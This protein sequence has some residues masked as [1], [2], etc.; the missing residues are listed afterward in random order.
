MPDK[1]T[2]WGVSLLLSSIETIACLAP[3]DVGLNVTAMSHVPAAATLAPHG[4][5][6]TRAKSFGL[7]P[8]MVIPLMVSAEPPVLVKVVDFTGLVGGTSF[9]EMIISHC[10]TT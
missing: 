3:V 8:P 6:E 4:V 9:T 5:D 1:V 2:F 10:G 7:V